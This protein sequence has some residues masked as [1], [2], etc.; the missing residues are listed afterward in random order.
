MVS[1][2]FKGTLDNCHAFQGVSEG[3]RELLES[4]GE[5]E[6]VLTDS[7]TFQGNSGGTRQL[8][9]SLEAEEEFSRVSQKGVSGGF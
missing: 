5:L 4:S 7:K 3:F 1:E 2:G 6:R 8:F 9:R